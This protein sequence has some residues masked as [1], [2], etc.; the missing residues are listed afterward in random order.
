MELEK[1]LHLGVPGERILF[2]GPYKPEAALERAFSVGARVHLDN[3]DEI[4]R[5][6]R[7]AERLGASPRVAI[8]LNMAVTGTPAW[9]RFGFNLDS[10]QALDAVRRLRAGGRLTLAGLHCHIGT[11]V[12]DVE[13]YRQEAAKM[14]GFANLLAREHGVLLDYLDLGGGFASRNTLHAQY[15][16]GEQTTPSFTAYAE[17]IADGL[18][19]LQGPPERMPTVFLETG[20]ALV[21]EAGSLVT[22]VHANKRLP[23]GR[24]GVVLDAGVNVLFTSNWYR[25]DVVPAQ[26]L[27]GTPEPTVLYGPL[28]MNIDVVRD[29]LLFPPVS[30]GDLLVVRSVGAYNVTQWM[31]F[32]VE[33]PAVV[34]ISRKG[35][36]SIIRRRETV[37]T[38]L[39]QE[40]VPAWIG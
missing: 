2:N 3:F 37:E 38:L 26:E 31:Q 36:A 15:L 28:C 14:A 24:R 35:E 17:A 12:Q 29:Q 22:T 16:P 13:A 25:H 20:R 19:A 1:A 21:D 39:G 7:V 4:L 11:F 34:M 5:A 8:R 9:S 32:I 10:G 40:E 6:E 33:R 27:T 23:D 30:P 18:S